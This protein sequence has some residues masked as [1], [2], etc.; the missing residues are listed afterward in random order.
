VVE[1]SAKKY[2]ADSKRGIPDWQQMKQARV[3]VHS[4]DWLVAEGEE[5]KSHDD[6]NT[7][8]IVLILPAGIYALPTNWVYKYKL[9]DSG[10]LTRFKAR[11]V[12]CGNRQNVDILRETYA[13][14]ARSTTLKVL[15]A[16]VAALDLECDQFSTA[17]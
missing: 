14:V 8:D 7:W 4:K 1:D 9:D 11:V 16:L 3:H 17:G 10:K 2:R 5:Y 6:N 13:A 12:V 15:L